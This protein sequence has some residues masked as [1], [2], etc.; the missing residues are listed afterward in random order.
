VRYIFNGSA[1]SAEHYLTDH[2]R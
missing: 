2:K 1:D